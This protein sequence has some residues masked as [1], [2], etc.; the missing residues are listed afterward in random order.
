MY[1]KDNTFPSRTIQ[2]CDVTNM[3]WHK[4]SRSYVREAFGQRI[5]LDTCECG[6]QFE[7]T[8]YAQAAKRRAKRRY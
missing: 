2:R 7:R 6:G 4:M 3:G 5:Y 8:E 1:Q